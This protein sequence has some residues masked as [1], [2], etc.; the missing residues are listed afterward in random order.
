M[1]KKCP[2]N[3]IERKK[4]LESLSL[5]ILVPNLFSSNK[6]NFFIWN[7]ALI[8]HR[9]FHLDL[10]SLLE[11]KLKQIIKL[12]PHST[13]YTRTKLKKKKFDDQSEIKLKDKKEN[14]ITIHNVSP[15]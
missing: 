5:S 7:Q 1:L 11:S 4:K 6:T 9:D 10:E 3:N 14:A 2:L 8:Q 12:N 13:Q 15:R